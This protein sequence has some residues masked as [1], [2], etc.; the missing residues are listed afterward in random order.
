MQ[1]GELMTLELKDAT[2]EL[3]DGVARFTL[4]RPE[5]LNA[6][7]EQMRVDFRAMLDFVERNDEVSVLI[8]G[9]E[10]RAFCAGGDV[11][12]MQA[13]QGT[14]PGYKSRDS[15]LEMHG[16][17]QRLHNLDCPVIAAVNGLAFGGGFALALVADFVIASTNAKF[18]SVFGRIG[19]IPDMALLYTLPRLLGMQKAKEIMYTARSI[20][21]QEAQALGLVLAVHAPEALD[22]EVD[23]FARRLAKGSKAAMGVTKQLVNRSLESDYQTMAR[24][25]ADGQALMFDTDFH[26]E[27]VDRFVGKQPSRYNW[28]ELTHGND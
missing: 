11:K 20:G 7:S 18:S 23:A 15:V 26:R 14:T 3:N 13:R 25:E 16:W 2:F 8:I 28:D 6:L 9:G 5:A 21:V 10:G 4:N 22:D 24:Y 1:K 12:R 17:L 27:A 19:L